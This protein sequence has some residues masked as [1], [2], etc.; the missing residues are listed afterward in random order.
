MRSLAHEVTKVSVPLEMILKSDVKDKQ[1]LVVEL[2]AHGASPNGGPNCMITPLQLAV[3]SR[4][5]KMAVCLL[6]HGADPSK[7]LETNEKF[8]RTE[9]IY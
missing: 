5:Y 6:Q 9:V 2:L 4:D 7:I 1:K 8:D 3:N